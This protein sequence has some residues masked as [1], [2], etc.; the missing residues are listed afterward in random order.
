[1]GLIIMPLS[2]SI[3]SHVR[4]R[5]LRGSITTKVNRKSHIL[6]LHCSPRL[7]VDLPRH[8]LV[9]VMLKYVHHKRQVDDNGKHNQ[10]LLASRLMIYIISRQWLHASFAILHH[11]SIVLFM[12]CSMSIVYPKKLFSFVFDLFFFLGGGGGTQGGLL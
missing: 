12:S 11:L 5:H 6:L 3:K 7:R 9:V 2:L 10:Y 1:M 8:G 4:K